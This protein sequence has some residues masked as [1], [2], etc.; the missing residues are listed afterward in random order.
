MTYSTDYR[1][2]VIS[3]IHEGGS[4]REAARLFKL[5]PDTIYQWLKRGDDLS[6]RPAQTRQR[7]LD[8]AA[9]ARHVETHPDAL[10]RERAAPFGVTTGAIW[11][12]L[13]KMKIVKKAQRSAERCP[14]K[15]MGVL[16]DRRRLI[17][18]Y[19]S[20][21]IVDVDETGFRKHA[22]RPHGWA[23]RGKKIYGDVSG[24]NRKSVNLIIAQRRKEHLAPMLFERSCG[25][26]VVNTWLEQELI[27]LLDKPS[28]VIMDIAIMDNAPFHKKKEISAILE[29]K[30]HAFLPLPPYSPDFNPIEKTFGVFKRT[31]NCAP[32]GTS[33]QTII[34]SDS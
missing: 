33:I 29:K 9:L 11:T 3:F 22:D 31:R 4:K 27:P 23:L 19:G 8:K 32:Q 6:P 26:L 15:R 18:V 20:A 21:N 16:R 14:M 2:R 30:G 34:V 7:K 5:S 24:C 17:P 1:R 12:A 10:L 25:H 13:R 28:I